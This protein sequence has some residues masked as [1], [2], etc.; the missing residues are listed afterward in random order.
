MLSLQMTPAQ[1]FEELNAAQLLL[2]E[3]RLLECE[4]A[5]HSLLARAGK[6]LE[7]A[8]AHHL[9]A[10]IRFQQNQLD[11]C[12]ACFNR[13]F[14]S[15]PNDCFAIANMGHILRSSGRLEQ[16]VR[17]YE[18]VVEVDAEFPDIFHYLGELFKD[19][20]RYESA[21]LCFR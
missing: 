15:F 13:Y 16:A 2:G 7:A 4:T 19:L 5:C 17:A 3:A 18:R 20:S 8:P 10:I 1:I 6:A 12:L 14:E 21:I 9:L 11:E